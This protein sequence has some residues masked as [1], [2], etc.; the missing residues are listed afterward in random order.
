MN[1]KEGRRTN[2]DV[3]LTAQYRPPIRR[4]LFL[5]FE[6]AGQMKSFESKDRRS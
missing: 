6:A 1:A 4:G 2:D 5:R 3:E